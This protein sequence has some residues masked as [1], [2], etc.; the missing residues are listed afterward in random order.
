MYCSTIKYKDRFDIVI[1][2]HIQH[3]QNVIEEIYGLYVLVEFHCATVT[4]LV[5]PGHSIDCNALV[6]ERGDMLFLS[7]W[8]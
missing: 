5:D 3:F 7:N 6:F 1:T 2:E 8:S 4:A